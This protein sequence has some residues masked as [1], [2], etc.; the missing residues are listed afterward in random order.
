LDYVIV[1]GI[2]NRSIFIDKTIRKCFV[3]RLGDILA[4]SQPPVMPGPCSP[5]FDLLLKTSLTPI[6]TLMKMDLLS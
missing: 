1:R 5:H 2:E 6:A 3:Q 4:E